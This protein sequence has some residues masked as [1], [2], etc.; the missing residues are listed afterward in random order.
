MKIYSGECLCGPVRLSARGE[1]QRVGICHCTNCRRES[2]SAFTYCRVWPA[3]PFEHSGA[4]SEFRGQHSCRQCGS[5]AFSVSDQEAEIKLG[6]LAEAPTSLEPSYELWVKRREPWLGVVAG[7][8]QH[9][10][11]R[12]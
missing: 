9:Q 8:E 1:P 3:H 4:T 7:A 11:D 6:L 5:P 12:K 10:E 2:G